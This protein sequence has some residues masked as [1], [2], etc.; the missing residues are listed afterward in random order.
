MCQNWQLSPWHLCIC[1]IVLVWSFSSDHA[2]LLN[3]AHTHCHHFHFQFYELKML[4]GLKGFLKPFAIIRLVRYGQADH[5]LGQIR[6]GNSEQGLLLSHVLHAK[7]TRTSLLCSPSHPW[8]RLPFPDSP[9]Q[10]ALVN[11][12]KQTSKSPDSVWVSAWKFRNWLGNTVRIG[13]LGRQPNILQWGWAINTF[14]NSLSHRILVAFV[15]H[16]VWLGK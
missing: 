2:L 12:D 7:L 8:P 4:Q 13:C 9:S 14:K 10:E 11:R 16:P 5:W 1:R 15:S 3:Q 6:A